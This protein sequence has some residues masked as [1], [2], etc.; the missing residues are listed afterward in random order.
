MNDCVSNAVSGSDA[1][2]DRSC[3]V[4][5]NR[6]NIEAHDVCIPR[7]LHKPSI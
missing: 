1:A 4:V 6:E 2:K 3:S 5:K 7:L